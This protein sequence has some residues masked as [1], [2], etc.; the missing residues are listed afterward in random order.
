V[1][2]AGRLP[3]RGPAGLTNKRVLGLEC[4]VGKVLRVLAGDGI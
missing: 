1:A 4:V 2:A 3:A